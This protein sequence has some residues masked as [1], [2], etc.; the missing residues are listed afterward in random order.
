MESASRFL[1]LRARY[2]DWFQS[3]ISEWP[4]NCLWYRG[5]A[6]FLTGAVWKPTERANS[7]AGAGDR[8]ARA[9]GTALNSRKTHAISKSGLVVGGKPPTTISRLS[10]LAAPPALAFYLR[11]PMTQLLCCTHDCSNDQ[12]M[13]LLNFRHFER[14]NQL[15]YRYLACGDGTSAKIVL[16]ISPLFGLIKWKRFSLSIWVVNFWH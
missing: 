2:G 5:R 4:S 9:V 16:N 1:R 7:A 15:E 14:Q 8:E 6:S 10:P 3:I 11:M 13:P 12:R